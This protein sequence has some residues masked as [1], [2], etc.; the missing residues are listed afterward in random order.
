MARN[1]KTSKGKRIKASAK[2]S[3]SKRGNGILE[4]MTLPEVRAFKPEVVVLPLGSTEPHG[5]HLPYGTDTYEARAITRLA[6]EKANQRKARVLLYPALPITNNVNFRKFPFALRIGVRTLMCALIDIVTQCKEDGI[7]K[8]VIFN[9][10][11]GNPATVHAT[12][13]EI[14]GMDDMP[15]V[16]YVGLGEPPQLPGTAF[17]N[18]I[19]HP[20]LHAGEF[21]TS[22]VM[23]IRPDLVQKDKFMNYPTGVEKIEGL[24]GRSFVRPWHLYVPRSAGGE[25]KESSAKKGKILVEGEGAALAELL[26]QLSKAPYNAKFPYK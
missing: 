18:P 10:H 23:H 26:V 19:K 11:G 3:S 6:V 8:V 17:K 13:R 9:V 1:A 4:E 2:A 25:T 14:A 12:M 20:S 24:D 15:F 7:K 5:D 22:M 21:E 16:Y